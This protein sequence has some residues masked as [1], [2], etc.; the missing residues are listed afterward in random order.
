MGN[1]GLGLQMHGKLDVLS[2][3]TADGNLYHAILDILGQRVLLQDVAV[4]GL[5]H[6][7]GKT[8]MMLLAQPFAQLGR[9]D[10]LSLHLHLQGVKK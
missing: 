6:Q 9:G 4:T 7:L 8:L 1:Y 5:F 3:Y 2:T 10:V